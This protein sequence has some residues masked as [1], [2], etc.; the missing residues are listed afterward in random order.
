MQ[1]RRLSVRGNIKTMC[2]LT[3]ITD[4]DQSAISRLHRLGH[5]EAM[6]HGRLSALVLVGAWHHGMSCSS[7]QE[8]GFLRRTCL[9]FQTINF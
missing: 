8:T 4:K 1:L 3:V 5:T 9:S 6:E 7:N 2:G